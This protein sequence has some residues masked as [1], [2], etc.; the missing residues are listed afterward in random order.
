MS[1]LKYL[2]NRS[3]TQVKKR[4]AAKGG[5]A[6][7]WTSHLV[8]NEE[9][10]ERETS[11][12]HFHWRNAQYPG[13]I[14]LMPVTGADELVVLDYGCGPGN[15]LVGFSEFSSPKKLIGVDVSKTALAA[16]DRRLALHSQNFDLIHIQEDENIIPLESNSVDLVHS[17]GVLHHAQNLQAAIHEIRR[18]LKPGGRLQVMVYNY[19]S[20]WLHLYTAYVLQIEMGRYSD[21]ALLD[22][23]RHS[24]DGPY[25]PI[26]KCYKPISFLE[27]IESHGYTGKF[28]GAAISCF[29]MSI[30][31]KRLAAIQNRS[32]SREHRDFLCSLEFNKYGHPTYSGVIAG[33]DA[34]YEFTKCE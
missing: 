15:D 22:A 9:F 5:S 8:V 30:L 19:D 32:L 1:Y 18:I 23:F 10:T 20:L 28:K 24:T 17:S 34:C 7:Y 27:E 29:E 21:L 26:S 4:I 14:D 31:P 11:L 16:A 25:C 2:I 12:D 3:V 13:Y 6:S 33:I